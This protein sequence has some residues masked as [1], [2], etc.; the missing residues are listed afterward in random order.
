MAWGDIRRDL[1]AAAAGSAA[2]LPAAFLVWWFG[3]F[4]E[5]DHGV[6][7]G[8]A[9]GVFCLCLF[10]PLVLPVLGLLHSVLHLLPGWAL[11]QPLA[12]RFPDRTLW[13][14]R[15]AG[16]TLVGGL[17][18]AVPA[19]AWDWPYATT[20][21]WCTGLG[22]WPVL[23][24]GLARRKAGVTGP[25]SGCLGRWFRPASVSVGLFLLVFLGG[26]LATVTGLLKEYEPPRLTREQLTG[27]WRGE[28]GAELRLLPGGRAVLTDVPVPE[29]DGWEA[30]TCHG[31]HTGTWTAGTR[32]GRTGVSLSGGCATTFWS[33]S[34]T[35]DEPE[36][37]VM[38]GDP[39][40]G[41][42]RV[43]ERD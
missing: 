17:W 40:S 8:G 35:E 27:V 26:V 16:G 31:T 30:A 25:S 19:M 2:Q 9:F 34:G 39:D 22:V 36:L 15:L 7:Y 29:P 28:D 13:A 12:R 20:A 33:A 1:D 14:W 38:F 37:F 42:L 6:G 10:L 11:V 41:D 32:D 5:D 21:L 43:L 24:V 23:W 3:T 18:A 4:T